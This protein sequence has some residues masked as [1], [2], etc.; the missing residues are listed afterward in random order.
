MMTLRRFSR[1]FESVPAATSWYLADLGEA[2]GKQELFTRQSPQRL[3]VLR[4]HALI[5]SA[6]SSNRIEGVEVDQSR[7]ATIVFGKALLRDRDEEEVRGYRQALTWIH[8]QGATLPV[9]EETVVTLHRLTRGEIWDAG[10]YKEKDGD[11]IE[12][13]PDGRS[14]IRFKT[15][16][17]TDTPAC[18]KELMELYGDA[19]DERRIPPLVLLVAFNLDFLC[20]H[21][22]RDGNGRVSRL[23]LL[24]QCYHLGFEVGRYISLERLIEQNKERYYETLAQSSQGW[25]EDKHD[26]WPYI[27]YILSIIKM[28]YREFE[29][30][31]G[32]LQSPKGEK[33]GLV[34]QAIDRTLGPFSVT[35]IQN[36][37]PSV[38]VDM[39]RRV[40]KNLRAKNH[41]ECLG[42]GQNARWQKTAKWQLGNVE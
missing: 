22:F 5:E 6:V 23:L 30:R 8:E 7:I 9:S 11:I 21:P 41:I 10:K 31:L 28:A 27:N 4:E 39:I 3:K 24:L 20:I 18:M 38:S 36:R 37:C 12:K 17:A 2:R 40:L 25:H 42:R 29:Q 35:E 33:T 19:V 15:V 1:K 32:Q 26:P 34:L 13:F 14:R 16:S